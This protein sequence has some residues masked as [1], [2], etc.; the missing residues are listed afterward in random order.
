MI[1]TFVSA[2][3]SSLIMLLVAASANAGLNENLVFYLTFDNIIDQRVVDKSGNVL[4]A[5]IIQN[6]E[7]AEGKYGNAIRFTGQSGDCVNIPSQENL[8]VTGEITMMLWVYYETRWQGRRMHFFDKDCHT[9]GWGICYGIMS[10]D[11]GNGNGPEIWLFL[12]SRKDQG[13][14][15]RQKLVI[16]HKMVAR[17]WHHI[18]G[19]YDG[20]TMKIYIDGKVIGEEEHKFNFA[21]D[22][23]SDVRIGC[24][25]ERAHVT[26]VNGSIDEAAVWQRALSADEINQAMEGNFL[27][28]S[29]SDKASTTWADIKERAAN[30]Y[31]QGKDF[32]KEITDINRFSASTTL[33]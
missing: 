3:F 11:T 17:K 9:N 1:R 5:E 22:N 23:D 2:A 27:A 15:V 21:G 6:T 18:A 8:K 32:E 20:E 4:D 26:F 24:A 13:G 14:Q 10:A 7:V 28:V 12:G 25:K 29:P 19:S 31:K 33:F 16:P 30:S